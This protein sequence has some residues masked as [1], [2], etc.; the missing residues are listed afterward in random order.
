MLAADLQSYGGPWT[1]EP[2]FQPDLFNQLG[3]QAPS[4]P[5]LP[6]PCLL[7]GRQEHLEKISSQLQRFPLSTKTTPPRPQERMQPDQRLPATSV[8]VL[9]CDLPGKQAAKNIQAATF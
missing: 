1:L 3:L 9:C 7:Q 5:G 2:P 8:S 4:D 6:R